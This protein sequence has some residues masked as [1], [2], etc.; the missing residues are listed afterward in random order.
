MEELNQQLLYL[1]TYQQGIVIEAFN[2]RKPLETFIN[3]LLSSQTN[4]ENIVKIMLYK[5]GEKR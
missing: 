2:R 1:Q 5:A 4:Q 3:M